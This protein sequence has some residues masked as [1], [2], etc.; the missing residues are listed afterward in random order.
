MKKVFLSLLFLVL[1]SGIAFAQTQQTVTQEKMSQADR[2]NEVYVAYGFG[3][4]YYIINQ[5]TSNSYSS[6]GTFI[7]GYTRS[8]SKLIGV[9]FQAGFTPVTIQY[10]TGSSTTKETDNYIQ[11]LA[12]IRFQYLNKPIFAMYSGV[13]IGVAMDFY[14]ETLKNGTTNTRQKYFPAGQFTLLGFRI[15]RG[16]AFCGEFGIG[17]LTFLNLGVSFKFGD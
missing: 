7:A 16:A 3:S 15:G 9:G 11:G 14:S 13:A 4:L 5:S 1:S 10:A 12:R 8:L 2:L 17:T 6:L